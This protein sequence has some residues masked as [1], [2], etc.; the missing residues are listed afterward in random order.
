MDNFEMLLMCESD[1]FVHTG[2]FRF[3]FLFFFVKVIIIHFCFDKQQNCDSQPTS[4]KQQDALCLVTLL[5]HSGLKHPR[6]TYVVFNA[7]EF[8]TQSLSLLSF[9]LQLPEKWSHRE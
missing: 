1:A 6:I 2:V 4:G 7:A 3:L 5:N 9:L 8:T